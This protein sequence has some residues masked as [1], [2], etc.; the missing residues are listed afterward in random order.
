MPPLLLAASALA[1][2]WVLLPFYGSIM[3]AIII[4]LLCVPLHR[5]LLRRLKGRRNTAA[6]LSHCCQ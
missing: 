1:V 5:W 4:A 6:G 3:W 2:G